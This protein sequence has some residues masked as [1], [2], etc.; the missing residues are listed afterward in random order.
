MNP[1]N[2]VAGVISAGVVLAVVIA[3]ATMGVNISEMSL[4]V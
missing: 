3:A 4:I 2:S 1:L